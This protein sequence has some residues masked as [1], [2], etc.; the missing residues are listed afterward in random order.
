MTGLSGQHKGRQARLPL[1]LG[2]IGLLIIASAAYLSWQANS[3]GGGT[4]Q[5]AV[6]QKVIDFGHLQDYTEKTFSI[7]V[8][9]TG[10]GTLRFQEKPY[11]QVQDGCCPPDLS[12]GAMSLK[13][14]ESTMVTS[15]TFRMHPGMDG[16]HD[17]AVHLVTNDSTQPD[18][19]V[20]VLSD[21][22]Q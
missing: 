16:K 13:P 3:T 2:A 5:L 7:K 22:S 18:V 11:V 10:T 21:W 12:V 15:A 14:G 20:H 17:Y 4:P 9:N 8:T 6:D 1:I 19:V